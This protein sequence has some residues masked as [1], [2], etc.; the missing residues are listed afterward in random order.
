MKCF[1]CGKEIVD[2]NMVVLPPDGKI[3]HKACESKCLEY[4]KLKRELTEEDFED[5]IKGEYKA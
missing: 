3:V 2:N 1:Y 4:L 5:F